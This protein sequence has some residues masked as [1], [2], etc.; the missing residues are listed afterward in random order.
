VWG[1][2]PAEFV[3]QTVPLLGIVTSL[4]VKEKFAIVIIVSPA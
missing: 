4:G 1:S 3:Q 2:E